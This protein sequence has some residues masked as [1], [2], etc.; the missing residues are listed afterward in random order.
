MSLEFVAQ[1]G[2]TFCHASSSAACHSSCWLCGN[3]DRLLP[4]NYSR[5]ALRPGAV[6]GYSLRTVMNLLHVRAASCFLFNCEEHSWLVFRLGQVQ[7]ADAS[8]SALFTADKQLSTMSVVKL[9]C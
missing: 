6:V 7:R 8:V 5:S 9:Q 4:L 1:R 3:L 2:S